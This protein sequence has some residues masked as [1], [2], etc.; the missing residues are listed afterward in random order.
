MSNVINLPTA[1]NN[2]LK[3]SAQKSV[4]KWGKDAIDRG[5]CIVPSILIRAQSRLGLS[6]TQLV[7]VINLIDWWNDPSKAPWSSKKDLSDRI[8]IKPRQ[9]QRQIAE[10][11][12][13]GLVER[14]ERKNHHGKIPNEYDLNG[15]VKKVNA[16]APEFK[17]AAK[18]NSEVEKSFQEE[19]NSGLAQWIEPGLTSTSEIG[20]TDD[21][22]R[23]LRVQIPQP[24][25]IRKPAAVSKPVWVSRA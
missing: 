6:T 16:L 15:L 2:P 7:I 12:K 11:E 20:I 17:K 8:G 3:E 18:A 1:A 13:A 5:Y 25:P 24:L 19:R 23:R 14:K 9:L 21:T 22:G 10:L 4:Q